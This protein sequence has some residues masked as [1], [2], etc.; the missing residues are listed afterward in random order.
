VITMVPSQTR[1]RRFDPQFWTNNRIQSLTP[2]QPS[3]MGLMLF[4]LTCREGGFIPGVILLGVAAAAEILGWEPD[5]TRKALKEL[6]DEGHVKAD[7]KARLMYI[8]GAIWTNQPANPNVVTGWS[9]TWHEVPECPLKDEIH[10]ELLA[11]LTNR[12]SDFEKA[13]LRA[14]PNGFENGFGNNVPNKEQDQYP[15]ADKKKRPESDLDP[16]LVPGVAGCSAGH[17]SVSQTEI[18]GAGP[19]DGVDA[20]SG[21]VPST[22]PGVRPGQV[23]RTSSPPT[24]KFGEEL[25]F[26]DVMD[27]VPANTGLEKQV[28]H[29]VD[30]PSVSSFGD[31]THT[32][33][34]TV[35]DAWNQK[36]AAVNPI[37]ERVEGGEA[38]KLLPLVSKAL[39]QPRA[40]QGFEV[41]FEVIPHD[42]WY[43]GGN[44][45]GFV[46]FLRHYVS[47]IAAGDL[48]AFD[49][50]RKKIGK[51]NR[52]SSA[53]SRTQ[54]QAEVE[55]MAARQRA[56]VSPISPVSNNLA[57]RLNPQ[58]QRK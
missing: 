1:Y 23:E 8:T 12:G 13:F 6:C 24:H 17:I 30:P 33:A 58:L 15:E 48:S 18:V 28:L 46:A 41:L 47:K 32:M 26:D 22:V 3:A 14:C 45:K 29:E 56:K 9:V 11:A 53:A 37:F 55:A 40:I 35:I 4:L 2:L 19:E 16:S 38:I 25:T 31:S 39:Q 49:I 42:P 51:L 44:D 50:A 5:A 36:V 34:Q 21:L 10:A 54:S 7:T 52:Q 20:S 57:E 27:D 43:A